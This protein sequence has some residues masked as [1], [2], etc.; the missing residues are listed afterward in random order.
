MASDHTTPTANQTNNNKGNFTMNNETI[1][2]EIA[3]GPAAAA[4]IK[5]LGWSIGAVEKNLDRGNASQ[6]QT[7]LDE[8][9]TLSDLQSDIASQK[10]RFVE[11]AHA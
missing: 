3:N 11:Q 9:R 8:Y 7:A 4:L 2:L 6:R 1:Y 5:S 10:R